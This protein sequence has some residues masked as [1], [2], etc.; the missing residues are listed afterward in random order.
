VEAKPGHRELDQGE[1]ALESQTVVGKRIEVSLS[2]DEDQFRI[3]AESAPYGISIMAPDLGFEYFNPKF[4]EIFGYTIKDLPDKRAWFQKAYP[5]EHYRKKVIAKWKE[6][7]MGERAFREKRPRIFKVR[8]KDGQDRSIRFTAVTLKDKRQLLTYQDVTEQRKA[9]VA[10]KRSEEKYRNILENIE[11]GY[12]EVD[13]SGNFTFFND[14]LCN[15]LGYS[16]DEMEGVNNRQ[17]TDKETAQEVY[18]AFS[19]VYSSGQAVK[20]FDWQVIRKDGRKRYVETSISLMKDEEDKPIGFRGIVRD[21]T[22][23]K[24]MLAELRKSERGFRNL[25][26]QSNDA[27]IIHVAGKIKDVNQRA[28]EMLGYGK[29]ELLTMEIKDLHPEKNQKE[30]K[31]RVSNAKTGKPLQFETQFLKSDGVPSPDGSSRRTASCGIRAAW[32]IT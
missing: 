3:L 18:K 24:R 16:R 25:F 22:N 10:L 15:M 5:D 19:H 4:S 31:E 29:D 20:G 28:C 12:Y 1:S 32:S 2:Q 11:D 26:E 8:C 27:I 9:R 6:D 17:Y 30:S 23:H 7:S 14:A 21:V 13:L